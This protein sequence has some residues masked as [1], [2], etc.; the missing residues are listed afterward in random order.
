MNQHST[1]INHFFLL[2]FP[3]IG[4]IVFLILLLIAAILYPGGTILEEQLQVYSF[5]YNFL[6]DMGRTHAIN[7]TVN[8]LS[9]SI[10]LLALIIGALSIIGFYI[11]VQKLFTASPTLRKLAQVGSAFGIMGCIALI[12]VGFT[13]VNLYR[14]LHVDCANWLFRLFFIASLLYSIAIFRQKDLPSQLA[15]GYLVFSLFIISY[16]LLNE[17]GPSP[18]ESMTMLAIK[19]IAQKS[20]LICFIVAIYFQSRGLHK[21]IK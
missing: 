12:G 8:F 20:I 16:I 15:I 3:Q 7:G 1:K 13:P 9:S 11:E 2:K 19:V 14:D 5:N 21:L 10:F 4:L 17:L 18:H 6:S